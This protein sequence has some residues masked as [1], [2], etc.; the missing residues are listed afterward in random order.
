M[1]LRTNPV[2]LPATDPPSYLPQ[3]SGNADVH[4]LANPM[5]PIGPWATGRVDWGALS[6]QTGTRPVVDRYSITRYSVDEWR[7]RNADTIGACADTSSKSE[8][9]E[10]DS[11]NTI[12]RTYAITDKIQADCTESLHNRAKTI[13]NMKNEL[14][15]AIKLM[16]D[17]ICLLEEQRRRLKQSLAV[18]RMPEAIGKMNLFNCLIIHRLATSF[19]Y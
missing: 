2:G 13:D 7:Q 18:L 17:E 11:K 14:Q 16:Q 12:I 3:R 8:K 5:G 19:F 9:I 1:E 15:T 6:G 4:P 10:H